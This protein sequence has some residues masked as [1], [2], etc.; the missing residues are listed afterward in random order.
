MRFMFIPYNIVLFQLLVKTFL[1]IFEISFNRSYVP[2]IV[3][4]SLVVNLFFKN[5]D[6]DMI[7][8]FRH[9]KSSLVRE[10][11]T[12]SLVKHGILSRLLLYGLS[13]SLFI[14]RP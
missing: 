7:H 14:T 11:G 9:H 12:L 5:N 3:N 1:R 13:P 8:S 6:M 10:L 2:N 4:S